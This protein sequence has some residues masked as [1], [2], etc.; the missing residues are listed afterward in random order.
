[1]A[2]KAR[3]ARKKAVKP[4]RIPPDP[5]KAFAWFVSKCGTGFCHEMIALGKTPTQARNSVIQMLLA[6][7]AGEACR[8]A[9]EENR[10]PNIDKWSKATAAAFNSAVE[11]TKGHTPAHKGKP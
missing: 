9:R 10:E 11:R 6:F 5:H 8:I 4:P 1:M 2:T 3:T 7:A